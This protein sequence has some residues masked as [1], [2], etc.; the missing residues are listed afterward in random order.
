MLMESSELDEQEF[1]RS[2]VRWSGVTTVIA[3]GVL[4]VVDAVA[5]IVA[6]V[7]IATGGLAWAGIVARPD[8]LGQLFGISAI[9]SFAGF[10]VFLAFMY[11]VKTMTLGIFAFIDL[12]DTEG[13]LS[14][15]N[16]NPRNKR[17]KELPAV[18]DYQVLS[19]DR[20]LA[21]FSQVA[22][23]RDYARRH[24][25]LGQIEVIHGNKS[26]A[27]FPMGSRPDA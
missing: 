10:G 19:P 24:T 9:A 22:D 27:T 23:A 4:V 5:C 18:H 1:W 2:L 15:N 21:S 8:F 16:P 7:C 13:P 3:V 12:K 6:L 14:S 20:W 17:Q 11:V 26:I 25:Q